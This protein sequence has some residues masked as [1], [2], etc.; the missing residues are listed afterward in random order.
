MQNATNGGGCESSVVQILSKP[1]KMRRRLEAHGETRTLH[2]QAVTYSSDYFLPFGAWMGHSAPNQG[3]QPLQ[4]QPWL[5]H[6]SSMRPTQGTHQPGATQS[7]ERLNEMWPEVHTDNLGPAYGT[8]P[9]R[10]GILMNQPPAEQLYNSRILSG[11]RQHR[12]QQLG[13]DLAAIAPARHSPPPTGR[14]QYY[15]TFPNCG[16]LLDQRW[17]WKRHEETHA[18]PYSWNCPLQSTFTGANIP[19]CDTCV[20]GVDPE[21]CPHK[22]QKCLR[23]TTSRRPFRRGDHFKNHLLRDHDLTQE[24]AR[25][26]AIGCR[27]EHALEYRAL[28]CFFCGKVYDNWESRCRCVWTHI[29][30]GMPKEH[31]VT[32]FII[33]NI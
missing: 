18:L 13:P 20:E 22:N 14:L 8:G 7:S 24:Q 4:D 33:S 3:S 5:H 16:E 32:N 12:G 23:R 21:N 6:E 17:K 25:T 31:W 2:T 28:S 29:E 10:S 1:E 26:I 15:C 11:P 30:N 19:T 27:I 9:W